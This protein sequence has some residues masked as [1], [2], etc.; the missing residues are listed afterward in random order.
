MYIMQFTPQRLDRVYRAMQHEEVSLLLITRAQDV[1]Y[2]TGYQTPRPYLPTACI[3][4]VGQAPKLLISELQKEFLGQDSVMSD[5]HPFVQNDFEF[6]N[7][8]HGPSFWSHIIETIRS[9]G[10]GSGIIGLQEDWL[11]VKDFDYLKA[12]LPSAGFRDFSSSL[13][14]LRQVK[15]AAEIDIITQAA[16]IAEI[17][18]RTALEIVSI[19][20]SESDVSVEIESAMRTAGGHLK[21]IRAAVISGPRARY[22]FAYPGPQ[23]IRNDQPVVIDITVSHG[24][25]FAEVARTIHLGRP[26]SMQRDLFQDN[27]RIV[28]SIESNM[29]PGVT[30]DELVKT[31]DKDIKGECSDSGVTK[32]LGSSIGLD[33]REPP[34]ILLGN[35]VSLRPGM[36]FSVYPSCYD[37]KAGVSKVADVFYV[38]ENGCE[39]ISTLARETV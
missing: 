14:K 36:V 33:L 21:G 34:H 27:V 7:P 35:S 23:R 1:Q 39:S 9:T 29:I 24:G 26:T 32:P 12:S 2:L 10:N 28:E 37:A 30:I 4:S 22:P 6:W 31:V 25:Y 11:S 13:W 17:G 15:D 8:S 5:V 18:V 3:V 20:K 19:E 38:T 16:R